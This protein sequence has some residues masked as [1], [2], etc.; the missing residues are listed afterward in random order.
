MTTVIE[1]HLQNGGLVIR[2]AEEGTCDERRVD[3][4]GHGKED[5]H[6]AAAVRAGQEGG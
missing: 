1:M 4:M 2:R 6:N 5:L 3:F